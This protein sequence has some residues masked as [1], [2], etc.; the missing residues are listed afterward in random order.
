VLSAA[1]VIGVALHSQ[2]QRWVLLQQLH[3][4][5]HRGFRLGPDAGLVGIEVDVERGFAVSF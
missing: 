3:H 2:A 1:G 5:R 4:L